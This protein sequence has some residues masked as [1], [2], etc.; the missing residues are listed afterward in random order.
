M[1]LYNPTLSTSSSLSHN[2]CEVTTLSLACRDQ[3]STFSAIPQMLSI[4][5]FETRSFTGTWGLL[6]NTIARVGL[7]SLPRQHW[8]YTCAPPHPA[9]PEDEGLELKPS[10]LH[11]RHSTLRHLPTALPWLS[12]EFA[13]SSEEQQYTLNSTT[14]SHCAPVTWS[15]PCS[16]LKAL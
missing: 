1:A 15:V 4:L 10:Y 14:L 6:V 5:C 2:L 13:Q 3:G 7:L 12:K 9:F 16:R 8:L 11:S